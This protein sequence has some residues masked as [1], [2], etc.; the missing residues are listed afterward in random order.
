MKISRE[1]LQTY[2]EKPLP[3]AAELARALTFHAFEIESVNPAPA[4]ATKGDEVLD[5]KITPNRGHDCLSYRGI[6]KEVS[7]ILK[8]P[9]KDDPFTGNLVLRIVGDLVEIAPGSTAHSGGVSVTINE[10]EL[11]PR[12]IAAYVRNVKVGPS[13][14]WLKERLAAMG[15]HSVNN[16]VDATN[17]VMFNLGQPLHAFDASK[18]RNN[19]GFA[20]GVRKAKAGEKMTALDGKEYALTDSMLVISDA[21][22]DATIG[23]AGI[24]GGMAASI[25]EETKDIILE[26]ANFNGPSVRK[27]AQ[28]LKLRTDASVRFEQELA[29]EIVAYAMKSVIDLI[30]EIAGGTLVGFTDAYPK[31]QEKKSVAV[32]VQKINGVLGTRL[33]TS[34]VEDAFRRLGFVCHIAGDVFTVEV[35]LE[36]LDITIA[37]DLVEEVGRIVGYETVTPIP[38][39]EMPTA[40]DVNDHFFWIESIRTQLLSRGFS[41]VYSSIF[42]EKGERIVLNKA[43]GVRPYLRTSL[44]EGLNDA[45]EKNARI[46]DGLGL[47]QV[48]IFEIGTVW[49]DGKEKIVVG[50]AVESLKKH[51]KAGDVAE[52][53][54]KEFNSTAEVRN[55]KTIA[56]FDLDAVGKVPGDTYPNAPVST[57]LHYE[58]F[59]KYPYI[60]RDIAL[61]VPKG[62]LPA[63]VLEVIRHH[64][65]DLLARSWKFD[66]YEKDDRMSYAF[67]L[68]FQSMD[69]TLFEDDANERMESIYVSCREKSWEV[70]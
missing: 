9:L 15:Q 63:E 66:E 46:K 38:L 35:P 6:A 18:L 58:T 65:G 51:P 2:F 54:L 69:R 10:P 62:M 12:Y 48:R 27:T 40:P 17:Y 23:I 57:T 30:S 52:E 28:A 61:W 29:P 39:P 14:K 36:R 49:A 70:R 45:L 43:D 32:S 16:V 22:A 59:S 1:W 24:K 7:A 50:V 42:A 68:V 5:V 53:V 44:T 31:L 19:D 60:V 41:E 33:S 55:H 25:M 8:L 37:E 26:A 11:V 64:A 20:I 47:S 4:S 67:R 56:E 3:E 13:P 34:N 21:Q